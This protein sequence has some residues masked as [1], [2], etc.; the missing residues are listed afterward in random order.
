MIHAMTYDLSVL[1]V[2][3]DADP[4]EIKA[5]YDHCHSFTEPHYEG[6]LDERIVN[7]YG[8]LAAR[9]PDHR[10]FAPDTPWMDTPLG[11]GVDHVSMHISYGARGT[12]AIPFIVE[13][14]HRHGLV[15]YD[16]Q[17]DEILRPNMDRTAATEQVSTD[18]RQP[19]SA[20]SDSN[21]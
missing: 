10:P 11:L 1:A 4:T 16:P 13:L 20:D 12:D 21:S 5:R 7:F 6:E 2:E 8:E 17:F 15:V 3:P 14:A 9:Y 19:G 18:R